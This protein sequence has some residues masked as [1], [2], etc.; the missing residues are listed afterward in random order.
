MARADTLELRRR[1]RPLRS[2]P[3]MMPTMACGVTNTVRASA[4]DEARSRCISAWRTPNCDLVRPVWRSSRSSSLPTSRS[5]SLT[6]QVT[7][8]NSPRAVVAWSW[9]H[10]DPGHWLP[11]RCHGA[12]TVTGHFGHRGSAST[13]TR[14]VRRGRRRRPAR[15]AS[16]TR[17]RWRR[18]SADALR[19]RRGSDSLVGEL[20]AA[21]AVAPDRRA[22]STADARTGVLPMFTSAT[23][24][25]SPPTAATPTIA[26]SWARRVNFSNA[27]PAPAHLGTR[28]SVIISSG[29]ERRLEEPEEEVVRRDPAGAVGPA[30]GDA[31]T[32]RERPRPGGRRRDR[33]GPTSRRACRGGGPAGRR[34][35][36]AARRGAGRAPRARRW[37]TRSQWRVSAPI[38]MCVAVLADA[39]EARR[40]R[41]TSTS[42]VGVA[43]R[44]FISGSSEWPPARSLASSPCSAS[45]ATASSTESA[46]T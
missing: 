22:A 33:R 43:S 30:H 7:R 14:R 25:R 4:A 27:H 32:E 39:V 31:A 36:P 2:S 15:A 24:G 12:A 8:P 40:R 9:P 37:S 1:I 38:T 26:Q 13:L 21:S 3:A 45:A 23:P 28:T 35:R 46:R 20:A 34:P 18:N 6:S 11:C 42:T 29:C 16:S 19:S 41:P 10:C 5:A 17:A 44:S